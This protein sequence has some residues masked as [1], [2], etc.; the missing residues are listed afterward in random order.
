MNNTDSGKREFTLWPACVKTHSFVDQVKAAAGAGFDTLA[1]SPV[2][3]K[4]LRA[5]G[6][7]NR[8]IRDYP[9][10]H[11][12][13]LNAYD[14]FSDWAPLRFS[15]DLP[16]AAQAIF[17]VSARECLDICE[18]LELDAICATGAFGTGEV[19]MPALQDGF[20][21][22]AEQARA[23]G[24]RV[25]L[26]FLPMW[27]IP[28]LA[29]AWNILSAS[30]PDNAG[31]LL[32]TWHFMRGNPDIPLLQSLPAGA[33]SCIQ[34]AD[35]PA[36]PEGADLFEDTLRYRRLPGEGAFPLRDILN[37]VP[38]KDRVASVGPEVYADALDELTA[39]EAASASA[40]AC[41]EVLDEV[42][43]LQ[44]QPAGEPFIPG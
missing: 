33:V 22:F 41:R 1:I 17:D 14:G 38:G 4:S 44:T 37:A 16:A 27:G 7:D 42:S 6:W 31:I 23:R 3:W 9:R 5:E 36:Q 40:N 8:K 10:D 43:G 13:R 26:E 24:V 28:D 12:V 29:S 18:A 39:A 2:L 21:R 11:G 20:G 35:G 32:D 25:D 30:R 19:E 34:L 15:P